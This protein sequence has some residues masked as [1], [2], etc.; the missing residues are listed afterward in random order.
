M[1]VHAR[2]YSGNHYALEKALAGAGIKIEKR[3][4]D[5]KEIKNLVALYKKKTGQ[6]LKGIQID[7]VHE[8]RYWGPG[9]KPFKVIILRK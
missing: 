9:I 4:Y 1:N 8:G 5:E 6:L 2:V 7:P 3:V